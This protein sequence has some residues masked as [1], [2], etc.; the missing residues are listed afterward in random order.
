MD[1]DL[2]YIK[3]NVILEPLVGQWYAWPLLVPPQTAAMNIT[4]S[5]I[6]IMKSYVNA[7]EVHAAAVRNPAMR[8]GPFLDF[9]TK[10]VGEIKALV[11]KSV[12]EQANSI[13][14]ADAIKRLTE[15]LTN[16]GKGHSLE[17]LYEKV[18]GILRGY[19]ELCYDINHR[20]LFRFI[21]PLLYKSPF[22]NPTLQTIMISIIDSDDRPFVFSTPRME[23]GKHIHLQIPFSSNAIDEFA[24]MR[25]VPRS[26]EYIKDVLGFSYFEDELFRSFLTIEPP[27]IPE[28][29]TESSLMARYLGHASVLIEAGGISFLTD[30]AIGYKFEQSALDNNYSFTDLPEQID[31][32]L[33]THTHADHIVFESLLQLRHRIKNILVPRNTGGFLE[34]PS[35][36]LLLK[37]IGFSNVIEVDDMEAIEIP[38]G[39]ITGIP[40]FGEHGDLAVR[41][42]TAYQLCIKGQSILF[43]ADSANLDSSLYNRVHEVVGD[44]DVL[45]IGMECEGAPVSW[46]YG[47]LM[48]KPL[49]RKMDQSRRLAASDYKKAFDIVSELNCK[50]V[51][52]YAMGQEPWLNFLTSIKYTDESKPIIESNKLVEACR[53]RGI[54]SERLYGVKEIFF[55]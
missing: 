11:E 5:H 24:K 27:A 40:F 16:E 6:K 55:E 43:T 12:K 31:Y 30:P 52:V 42:K 17:G 10:R 51:Y 41:S 45:F 33:I 2:F 18:P 19:V 47:P 1:K 48:T 22:Y 50:Q 36:K 9:P 32:V 35:I 44:V 29:R 21:E 54:Q 3:P 23:D 14:L 53:S 39:T 38:G 13:E 26:F 8:G 37:N 4:N 28:K 46:A 20:P 7:P 15:I 34:D 49:D 25:F